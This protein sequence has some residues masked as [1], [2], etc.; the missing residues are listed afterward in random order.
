MH[1]INSSYYEHHRRRI[2]HS[3]NKYLQCLLCA[4]PNARLFGTQR[5]IMTL[6][7]DSFFLLLLSPQH[8]ETPGPKLQLQ[9]WQL[10]ILN[11]L[12]KARIQPAPPQRQAGSLTCYTTA[13]TPPCYDSHQHAHFLPD[14]Y[15][16]NLT[17]SL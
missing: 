8:M 3:S 14:I 4:S 17:L 11:P 6:Y 2:F 1:S 10:H 9:Q 5:W 12:C 15:L 13:G 16:S 7:Y